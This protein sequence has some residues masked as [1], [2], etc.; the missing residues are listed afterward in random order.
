M[1]L[2]VWD[3]CF[4]GW[5]VAFLIF[6]FVFTFHSMACPVRVVSVGCSYILAGLILLNAR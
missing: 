3:V 6:C 1:W 4:F 5:L 2:R